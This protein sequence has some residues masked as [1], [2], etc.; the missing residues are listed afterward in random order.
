MLSFQIVRSVF[1]SFFNLFGD[2]DFTESIAASDSY[3]FVYRNVNMSLLQ[4]Y[5][6]Y[7][8]CTKYNDVITIE[9]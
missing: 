1:A 7:N 2:F 3:F 9:F 8:T 5:Q 4:N 6:C